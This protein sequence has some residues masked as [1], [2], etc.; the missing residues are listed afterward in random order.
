MSEPELIEVPDLMEYLPTAQAMGARKYTGEN[1][2]QGYDAKRE[3]TEKWQI[4]Q[5]IICGMLANLPK[6]HW[7][8]D[9]PCGTGRFF[10]YYHQQGLCFRGVDMSADQLAAASEKIKDPMKARLMQADVRNLP[11]DDKSVDASVMCR[12]TRWLSPEDC[13]I[14]FKELM[15]VTRDRI[16]LTVRVANHPHERPVELFE[17]VC[18]EDWDLAE[19]KEGYC[20]DYRILM[21]KRSV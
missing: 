13:Q 14:A 12:M 6:G 11:L 21:F 3:T 1:A 16:I 2:G 15:R 8:L 18:G 9:V 5:K 20:P 4:E 10:S 17:S 19:N 7:V